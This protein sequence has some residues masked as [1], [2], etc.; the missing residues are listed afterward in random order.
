[1]VKTR[2]ADEDSPNTEGVD[3]FTLPHAKEPET[4]GSFSLWRPIAEAPQNVPV[5]LRTPDGQYVA[6]RW[7][8]TSKFSF[9]KRKWVPTGFWVILNAS[10]NQRVP[11][12]PVEWLPYYDH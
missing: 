3:P 12:E 2:L 11:F 1:M 6:A 9:L 7:R 4:D 5:C 10:G 8:A